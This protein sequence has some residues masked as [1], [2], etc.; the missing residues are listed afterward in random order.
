M[1]SD[2]MVKVQDINV[3]EIEHQGN[4]IQRFFRNRK[5]DL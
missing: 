3:A 5:R 2:L 1:M 4:F